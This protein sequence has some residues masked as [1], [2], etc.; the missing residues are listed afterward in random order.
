M[1]DVDIVPCNAWGVNVTQL[2]EELVEVNRQLA[3]ERK[4]NIM[5]R[6]TLVRNTKQ[7]GTESSTDGASALMK[8]Y[9]LLGPE[10][11][12]KTSDYIDMAKSSAAIYISML[13]NGTE[14][15]KQHISEKWKQIMDLWG[16]QNTGSIRQQ[17]GKIKGE[18]T[19][20]LALLTSATDEGNPS[21]AKSPINKTAAFLKN[22]TRPVAAHFQDYMNKTKQT[23]SKLSS[24]LQETWQVVKNLSNDFIKQHSGK[25]DGV[26]ENIMEKAKGVQRDIREKWQT[27]RGKME[28]NGWLK[29]QREKAA[30]HKANHPREAKRSRGYQKQNHNT[31]YERREREGREYSS[32]LPG[33]SA[34]RFE[35]KPHHK[36]R[37]SNH[38]QY[39]EFWR[40]VDFDPDD[41]FHEG[42]FEGNQRE[43]RKHQER[44]KHL[45]DR[46]H[47]LNED[48]LYSMDDDDIEDIYEDL[49][50]L[51]DDM[52]DEDQPQ[53]LQTWLACQV[54]WWKS[55][56]QRKH[57]SQ[58]LVKGCGR[59]IMQWQL[60][61]LCKDECVG[62]RCS[63][64]KYN[65]KYLPQCR[66]VFESQ[67][68]YCLKKGRVIECHGR[69]KNKD[70]Q[71]T[72]SSPHKHTRT[73]S[74]KPA[75]KRDNLPYPMRP[76]KTRGSEE[77]LFTM[78]RP[79]Q[80]DLDEDQVNS[81]QQWD[82]ESE[83]NKPEFT[84]EPI[85]DAKDQPSEDEDSEDSS[86]LF[87]RALVREY[88]HHNPDWH[89]RR[90]AQRDFE[91]T[92]PWYV[93]RSEGRELLRLKHQE[94]QA[95]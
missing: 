32:P 15:R 93:G 19:E 49:D 41:Y 14:E 22:I 69:E 91:R 86:W 17:L 78:S 88:H 5:L 80:P 73:G 82:Q 84:A 8:C 37:Q 90:A 50:D 35:D 3:A 23:V 56:L 53:I 1:P 11:I 44:L 51:Q 39:N 31:D 95:D 24:T 87:E 29:K 13:A 70:F 47:R 58:D 16:R 38:E 94:K 43:W 89:F 64:K 12:N 28:K 7:N 18:V 21:K 68:Y 25:I 9:R 67:D 36:Q 75:D 48:I 4:L 20:F 77:E 46:I 63:K 92:K 65:L 27:V 34:K 66:E 30:H 59:Q 81:T 62:K 52:D 2:Q 55:R 74:R 57:R 71:T 6:L 33:D 83:D 26:K 85:E 61:A 45:H 76:Q 40:K 79:E 54:R 72:H 60:R 10:I 42:F